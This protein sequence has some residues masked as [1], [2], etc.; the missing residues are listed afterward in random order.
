MPTLPVDSKGSVLYYEDSGVPVGSPDYVTVVLVHG[1]CFHGAI[2]RPLIPYAVAQ[3]LRLVLLNLRDY[4]GSTPYSVE[5][6]ED[7][8][9]PSVEAHSRSLQDRGLELATFLRRFIEA[10][11][12]PPIQKTVGSEELSGGLSLLSWSGGNTPS[13]AML[14]HGKQL[15]EETRSL[16]GTYL[17]SFIMYDPS[18]FVVG[19]PAPSGLGTLR[20]K[21]SAPTEVQL[22]DFALSVSSYYPPITLPNDIDPPPTYDPPRRAVHE[23]ADEI[24]PKYTPTTSRMAPEV[25]RSVTHPVIFEQNQHLTWAISRDVCKANLSCALYDCRFDDGSGMM[26]ELWPTIRVHVVWCDMTVGDCAWAA[27]VIRAQYSG[28]TPKHQRPLEFHRLESANHFVH[29]DE[30]ERFVRLLARIA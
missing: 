23:S 6:I 29:W 21:P 16:L 9:S 5:D 19:Q 13:V 3:N 10:E 28:A 15:S 7:I 27:A 12:I 14:A 17:R 4:P 1:T 25:L 24:D 11:S 30:P 20:R 22:A 8:R 2:Y 26:K 18:S